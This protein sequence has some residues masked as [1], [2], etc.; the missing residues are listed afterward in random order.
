MKLAAESHKDLVP[1]FQKFVKINLLIQ[2]TLMLIFS[3]WVILELIKALL[4][5]SSLTQLLVLLLLVLLE[6]SKE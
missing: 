5:M 1:I 4:V 3:F 6:M 2:L